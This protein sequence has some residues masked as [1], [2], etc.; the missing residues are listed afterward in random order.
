[1]RLDVPRQVVT[2]GV[3]GWGNGNRIWRPPFAKEK[4]VEEGGGRVG[5]GSDWGITGINK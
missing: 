4:G 3:G 1:M 2:E 5:L